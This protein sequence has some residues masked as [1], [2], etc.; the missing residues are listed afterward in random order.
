[1]K[2][3]AKLLAPL[4]AVALTACEDVP[5]PYEVFDGDNNEKPQATSIYYSSTNLYTGWSLVAVTPEQ[6]WSQGSSYTQ[7]TGYQKWDGSDTKSNR[8]VK[9]YLIS[10]KF[11]T[12]AAETGKVKMSFNYT[13]RYTNNVSGWKNNHKVM[14]SKDYDGD[15]NNFDNA[16]WQTLDVDLVESPY[17]DWTLYPSGDIQL[18]DEYVN[19]D[20]VY[21]AFYF[22]A[23][24]SAST[25]WELMDF[26]ITDGVAEENG[27]SSGGDEPGGDTAKLPYTSPNL[28][29]A[30]NLVETGIGQ[31][32]SQGSSY[33][34]ATGYQKWDGSDTKSNR[35]VKGYLVSPKFNTA[36]PKT[37]KVKMSFDYTIRYTNN[38]S[39]WK[40][41][42]KAMVSKDYSGNPAEFDKATWTDLKVEL[43]ESPYADWTL[44]PS[45]DIQLPDEYVNVDGVYVAFYFYAPATGSTTWE[46][47]NFAISDGVA[48]AGGSEPGGDEPDVPGIDV[49]LSKADLCI[50]A[51]ALGLANA[52]AFETYEVDGLTVKAEKGTNSNAPKYYTTGTAV[53]MYPGNFMTLAADR[54]IQKLVFTCVKGSVANNH[55]EAEP[56][57]V[58]VSDPTVLIDGVDAKEVIVT[59]AD[60][61]TGTA[62]QLRWQKLYVFYA[63]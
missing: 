45:G 30:W 63:Q 27:G 23:P 31:P 53:R 22:A 42:H 3:F 37:G 8:E 19:V 18:P 35:E 4:F 24:A 29:T 20:G 57:S 2:L 9:G 15:V 17:T 14:V 33:T 26:V 5:A 25:T 13:I 36:A 1:M 59:N 51:S 34:Q 48:E 49:D 58:T 46:L 50:D 32:W 7:A 41:N 44:Y 56:G 21:V 43:K 52:A 40:D 16:T 47:M 11:N 38:V 60:T 61:S 54:K 55:V 28:Y 12:A 62:S 39:G 10:P 6:P